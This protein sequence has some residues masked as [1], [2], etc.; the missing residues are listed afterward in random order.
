MNQLGQCEYPC[1]LALLCWGVY[2]A[3]L[4]NVKLTNDCFLPLFWPGLIKCSIENM[5]S[6]VEK[7]MKCNGLEFV[8]PGVSF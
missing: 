1:L 6:V 3:D 8:V 7:L 5:S 2:K 4:L